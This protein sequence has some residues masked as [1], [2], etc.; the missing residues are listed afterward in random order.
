MF[1][2]AVDL[3]FGLKVL[4][5]AHVYCAS[6]AFSTKVSAAL[7][8]KRDFSFFL[9]KEKFC[10]PQGIAKKKK[11]EKIFF[12]FLF[13]LRCLWDCLFRCAFLFLFV[14]FVVFFG[15]CAQRRS[16]RTAFRLLFLAQ[17]SPGFSLFDSCRQ[18]ETQKPNKQQKHR[19]PK[20]AARL[21][22][23]RLG[24]PND[25][26]DGFVRGVQ[27]ID[28]MVCFGLVYLECVYSALISSRE[29][30]WSLGKRQRE[31]KRFSAVLCVGFFLFLF[32][33]LF[34]LF[35]SRSF[36]VVGKTF[37]LRHKKKKTLCGR[38]KGVARLKGEGEEEE[39]KRR[40]KDGTGD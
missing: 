2:I 34:F 32:F 24:D 35:P 5:A 23:C 27:S 8:Q 11:G 10:S 14:Y 13:F 21:F 36:H 37:T 15:C 38:E 31:G 12:L 16:I 30:E 28:L 17:I 29:R 22:L 1:S 33:V 19:R 40:K 39:E 6:G 25:D 9:E 4:N 3:F 26:G 7:S 20:K 18:N